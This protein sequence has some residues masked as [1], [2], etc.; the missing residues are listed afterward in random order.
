MIGS[1]CQKEYG[2]KNI[3]WRDSE[4]MVDTNRLE[5]NHIPSKIE[6]GIPLLS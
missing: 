5:E 1:A 3:Q 2:G 4:K 6:N